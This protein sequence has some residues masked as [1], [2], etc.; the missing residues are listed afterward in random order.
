MIVKRNVAIVGPVP[1][2][3][4]GVGNW[5]L[6]LDEYAEKRDDVALLHINTAPISRGLDG[7]GI[8]DRVVVQGIMMLRNR[9][10]LFQLIHE[11]SPQAIHI[12]TSGQLAIIRDIQM[13]RIAKKWHINSVYH[14]RFGRIPEIAEANAIEWRLLKKAISLAQHVIAI[15][16]GT[17]TAIRMHCPNSKVSYIPN[18][19][20]FDKLD[21]VFQMESENRQCLKE[22]IFVGWVIK[23]KGIEEL[24]TAWK[25]LSGRF[26]DWHL[27]IIGPVADD[28]KTKLE[29]LISFDS[30]SFEGEKSHEEAMRS[31]AQASIATLPSYTEGFPNFVLEAMALEKPI[32]AT[33][34][35]AISEM[36]N[37]CGVVIKPK[38]ASGLAHALEGL[39]INSDVRLKYGKL[40]RQKL[41][42]EYNMPKIFEQYKKLWMN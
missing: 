32:V 23:T 29:K 27:R 37:G 7:R 22:V 36:L 1:P 24:L 38:D 19:F 33:N 14:I 34:V 25:N 9:R 42:Q 10:E 5:V 12:T 11:K 15:D 8:W 35:G 28:Y 18:P 6:M 4:G 17:E 3:Y 21:A 39:M 13:L 41:E 2:P 26:P 20:Y 31:L 40:A 16:T 30:V